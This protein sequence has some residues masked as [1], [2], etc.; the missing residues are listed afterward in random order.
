MTVLQVLKVPLLPNPPMSR[1]HKSCRSGPRTNLQN[2]Q[3]PSF[4]GFDG[5]SLAESPIIQTARILVDEAESGPTKPLVA[6]SHGGFVNSPSAKSLKIETGQI[7]AETAESEPT[8]PSKPPAVSSPA[9]FVGFEGPPLAESLNVETAQI[10]ADAAESEPTKPSEPG[11]VGFVG[12]LPAESPKIEADS[13]E[14]ARASEVLNRAG[15]RI[16][17]LEG[18]VTMG[19]WSDLDAMEIRAALRALRSDHLPVRYLDSGGIPGRYKEREVAG[20]SVPREVRGEMERLQASLEAGTP[21]ENPW[22]ARDRML[23][24]MATHQESRGKP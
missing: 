13:A 11:S 24:E 18:G 7:L 2:H 22:T 14:L 19:V 4:V 12:A 1:R 16:M 17:S 15:V 3:K 5:S 6:S 20:A 9:G 21:A 8:K 10:L 23:N